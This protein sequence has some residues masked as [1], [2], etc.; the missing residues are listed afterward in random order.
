MRN[1]ITIIFLV[2][3]SYFPC[4]GQANVSNQLQ[5]IKVYE[6]L[7]P[8]VRKF[9]EYGDFSLSHTKGAANISIPIYN[10]ETKT[11]VTIPISLDY[12]SNG[13]K[14][15]E[16]ASNVGLGWTLNAFG[17]ITIENTMKD[18]RLPDLGSRFKDK[19][20]AYNGGAKL[21]RNQSEHTT[22]YDYLESVHRGETNGNVP[23]FTYNFLGNSGKFILDSQGKSFGIPYSNLEMKLSA[24]HETIT[25]YDVNGNSYSFLKRQFPVSPDVFIPDFSRDNYFYVLSKIELSNK[26]TLEFTY[27]VG[28]ESSFLYHHEVAYHYDANFSNEVKVP[29]EEEYTANDF[30]CDR[31]QWPLDVK[32]KIIGSN[33]N[34][35]IKQIK[36]GDIVVNFKYSSQD[37]LLIDNLAYRRDIGRTAKALKKIEVMHNN[38]LIDSH[39]L[40]YSY[41]KSDDSPI[42]KQEKYRLKLLSISKNN[43]ENHSFS[44]FETKKLPS[45]DSYAMD[46]YGY[47]NGKN[48]NTTLLPEL[49][50]KLNSGDSKYF[51]G[52]NRSSGTVEEA[53]A[54]SLKR[55]TFPTKG[56]TEFSYER[57][58]N[59]VKEVVYG[60]NLSLMW[61]EKD[62][63]YKTAEFSLKEAGYK[64][65]MQLFLSFNNDCDNAFA[66]NEGLGQILP[67]ASNGSV[68]IFLPEGYYTGFF[69]NF[70]YGG[71]TTKN[72]VEGSIRP[73]GDKVIITLNRFGSCS[74]AGG[75][76]IKTKVNDTITKAMTAPF[77]V[78]KGY[79]SYSSE[80]K[81]EKDVRYE[82]KKDLNSTL[83]DVSY[84]YP[85]FSG[86]STDYKQKADPS[87]KTRTC[88]A[89]MRT[90]SAMNDYSEAYFPFVHVIQQNLGRTYYEYNGNTS[91]VNFPPNYPY[92]DSSEFSILDRSWDK[93]L[94]LKEESYDEKNKL[95][96]R[97]IVT[98][99]FDN[100]FYNLSKD[101][102]SSNL[103]SYNVR[104]KRKLQ[105]SHNS[106]P[107]LGANEYIIYNLI[108]I[109]STWIK[110]T[111]ET[112]SYYEGANFIQAKRNYTYDNKENL[113][114]TSLKTVVNNIETIQRYYYPATSDVLYGARKKAEVVKTEFI[115][116]GEKL[117]TIEN[118]YKNWGN[119]I[120]DLMEIKASKG[121]NALESLNKILH[122]D[123]KNGNIIEI[124]QMDG[125]KDV[126]LYG[127]NGKYLIS[128]IQNSSK[129]QVASSLGVTVT[130]IGTINESKLL[131]INALRT[132]T[133]FK[134]SLIT[135]Y[136]HKPLVGI[137]KIT[138]PNGVFQSF[139]YDTNNRLKTIKD[140]Q[141]NILQ[142]YTY[143]YQPN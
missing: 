114:P 136:E 32:A 134:E 100:F 77:I 78:L 109:E 79:K 120:V 131:Q 96:Y 44:Y 97:N 94:L 112:E 103:L 93:D 60:R 14:V 70:V 71:T 1:I 68:N 132:N 22:F 53:M 119:G 124:Q 104:I 65:G 34:V 29:L 63:G 61:S 57:P 40:N 74:V 92:F 87:I 13:I 143:Q 72:Y 62:Q 102:I 125:T 36:Y 69:S 76:S 121:S 133:A 129:E 38:S 142:E 19:L 3:S 28:V 41:F 135:T 10:L 12:I 25:I 83:V 73:V 98:Y 31:L 91:A 37:G 51:A 64:D 110:K 122:R 107:N 81:V 59:I 126:Y 108:P 130:N 137:T 46:S 89:I 48:G 67:D 20:L 17:V 140:Q 8:E 43:V 127:Y 88:V 39:V 4:F 85:I 75:F 123:I 56:F 116:N 95:S 9:V 23:V 141:G 55:I 84:K 24:N 6:N 47:Y 90:S 139:D 26:E 50:F 16:M 52:A 86:I 128:K 33:T 11:G 54:F 5:G 58:V 118:S 66:S 101:A 82:Y 80:G 27:D 138:N 49:S 21:Y 18:A 117:Q 15:N 7:P 99:N 113:L 42:E 115:K 45:R 111:A 30:L 105:T 106:L 2:S 35:N